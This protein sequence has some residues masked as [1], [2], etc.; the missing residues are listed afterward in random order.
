[1]KP[2]RPPLTA[3][4]MTGNSGAPLEHLVHPAVCKTVRMIAESASRLGTDFFRKWGR[5]GRGPGASPGVPNPPPGPPRRLAAQ[6]GKGELCTAL[7]WCWCWWLVWVWRV[8]HALRPAPRAHAHGASLGALCSVFCLCCL[9]SVVCCLA[10]PCPHPTCLQ[11]PQ[12][13]AAA[14]TRWRDGIEGICSARP[15]ASRSVR[16]RRSANG[17]A[18]VSMRPPASGPPEW[19]LRIARVCV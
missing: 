11:W 14:A 9:L 18:C 5:G 3:T 4:P 7:T 2:S 17:S 8:A 12:R 15:P 16:V 6:G 19:D 13:V 10:A 1:M